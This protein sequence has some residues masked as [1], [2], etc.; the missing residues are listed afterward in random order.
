[1][2]KRERE[3][4]GLWMWGTKRQMGGRERGAIDGGEMEGGCQGVCGKVKFN[5]DS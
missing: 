2:R 3:R 5:S 1:M 4:N